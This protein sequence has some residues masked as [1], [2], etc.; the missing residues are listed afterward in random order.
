MG[1]SLFSVT[2]V[3]RILTG[4][5]GIHPLELGDRRFLH[6]GPWRWLRALGWA[7]ALFFLAG[8][9]LSTTEV[10]GHVLPQGKPPNSLRVFSG[11]C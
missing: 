10:I 3:T 8:L 6:P 9:S 7:V 1:T 5:Q 2:G 11:L 4:G